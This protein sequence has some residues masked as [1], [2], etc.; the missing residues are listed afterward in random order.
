[1]KIMRFTLSNLSPGMLQNPAPPE[2]LEALRTKTPIAKR[3]D[4]TLQDEAGTKLYRSE[5]GKMGVPTQNLM[6]SIIIAGRYIKNGKKAISTA[7]STTVFDFLEFVDDFCPFM[8][9]DKDGNVEWRPF[10]VRGVMKNGPSKVAVCINRPRIPKWSL[11]LV[12]KFDDK[13]GISQDTVVSLVEAAG[14]KVGLCDWRPATKGRFG[15]SVV[16]KVEV[17]SIA[18][19]EQV[20]E[21]VEFLPGQPI[22]PELLELAET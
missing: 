20:V 16:T 8:N 18:S 19:N 11:Q 6:S 5:D 22:P 3:T 1:M 15:R 12:V 13:R 9:C 10:P 7:E 17:V 21:M 2:L 4:W 14:R